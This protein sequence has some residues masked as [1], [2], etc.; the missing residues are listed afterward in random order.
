[1]A[2][3][4]NWEE[5]F[6]E[7]REKKISVIKRP[8]QVEMLRSIILKKPGK[9]FNITNLTLKNDGKCFVSLLSVAYN[10]Q[11]QYLHI[12][13]NA[14]ILTTEGWA[15]P[16]E[17][18]C[19][20]LLNV[21]IEGEA[22]LTVLNNNI[23]KIGKGLN[24]RF[25]AE[26]I[27]TITVT[28][29]NTGEEHEEELVQYYDMITGD[30]VPLLDLIDKKTNIYHEDVIIYNSKV[31][32]GQTATNGQLKQYNITLVASNTEYD[33]EK[34]WADVT[35]GS[36][37]ILCNNNVEVKPKA[38]A[39]ANARLS[40]FKAPSVQI[41][42]VNV[43]AV[44]MGKLT[45]NMINNGDEYRD[46]FGFLAS[47]DLAEALNN[48]AP[49]KYFFAPWACN[50][51]GMQLRP[52]T[53]KI[54]AEAVMRTYITEFIAHYGLS[55]VVLVRGQ[56]SQEDREQFYLRDKGKFAGKVV[57]IC[58]DPTEAWKISLFTDLNGMKAPFDP[59][60]ESYY[61][62]LDMT[63]EEHNV[64]TGANTSTQL[65]QSMM[66]AD[67]ERTMIFMQE[68]A[69]QYIKE[70]EELLTANDGKPCSWE[71]LHNDNVNYQ[72]LLSHVYPQFAHK[73][74]APLWHSIVDNTVKG[75][76][77]RIRK[78][79]MPTEGAYTKIITDTSADFGIRTLGINKE[80]CVEIVLPVAERNGYEFCVGIKYPKQGV[81]EYLKGKVISRKE[82]C[83]RIENNPILSDTQ[84]QLIQNH[85]MNLS[86]GL[87]MI[88]AI[89]VMK[90]QLAGCDFDGDSLI[91]FFNETLVDIMFT[92][93]P[94]AVIIDENDITVE[95][96]YEQT[97]G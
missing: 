95:D 45:F 74:Y 31:T 44:Y 16:V 26:H 76:V 62:I 63:H 82:Y 65:L 92:I 79:N 37:T 42:K 75:Y 13:E 96:A 9:Q 24:T 49:D 46:G 68:L 51:I 15:R 53:N 55:T 7:L 57:V 47:E 28:D 39:Q 84:K 29:P 83:E 32:G 1:M 22:A 19:E 4:M 21:E 90:N 10:R 71:A 59:D 91:M 69:E 81:A 89:E 88:P 97:I 18:Y 85:I 73:Y 43:F 80:G 27:N 70:K 40:A 78:L 12:Q 5:R 41:G 77:R 48:I 23:Y 20:D 14:V 30:T 35:Y 72:E 2:E 25:V 93:P 56:I 94:K 52:W 17:R 3:K 67:P 61:E 36:S 8:F 34:I 64:K 50:G 86:G 60:K 33:A 66:I 58:N 11:Y 54:F 6:A 87:V 38:I